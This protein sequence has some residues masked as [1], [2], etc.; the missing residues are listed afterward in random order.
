LSIEVTDDLVSRIAVLA[1]LELSEDEARAM[2]E[3]FRKVLS[4]VAEL[5]ELDTRGVDPSLFALEASNVDREDVVRSGL[6]NAQALSAAPA[7]EPPFFVVPR[8]VGG[9]EEAPAGGGAVAPPA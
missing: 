6:S 3:H 7:S 1:R 9:G 2:K 4:Y 5:Q 8:I